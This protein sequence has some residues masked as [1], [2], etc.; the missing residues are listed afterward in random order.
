MLCNDLAGAMVDL[1]S[2]EWVHHV[3]V[4]WHTEIWFEENDNEIMKFN[5]N[6]DF[7]RFDL[8]CRICDKR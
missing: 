1:D 7:T 4:N 8:T 6:L 5:G 3:C 2:K